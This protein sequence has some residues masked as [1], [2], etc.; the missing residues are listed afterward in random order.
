MK[1]ADLMTAQVHTVVQSA[2][3]AVVHSLMD[4][5]DIRHVPV[6][7]DEGSLVGL[8]S[9]RDV[10]RGT[11][12]QLAKLP[13]GQR[14]QWLSEYTVGEVMVGSPH[15]V[16]ADTDLIDAA[17]LM[18]ENKFGCLPV[19]QGTHLVGILTESD[20]VAHVVGAGRTWVS[21]SG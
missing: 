16:E 9:H 15:A 1:V 12:G 10:L 8:V 18:L 3:L 4:D 19:V 2:S 21:N 11:W 17:E 20:F 14:Q 13:M 5:H 7:D 6:V